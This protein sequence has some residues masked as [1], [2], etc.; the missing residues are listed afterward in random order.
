M[1]YYPCSWT[2]C[3][4]QNS[5]QNSQ[6]NNGWLEGISKL[7]ENL[8]NFN[9]IN[10]WSSL[11]FLIVAKGTSKAILRAV[12]I[13]RSYS[14]LR[15]ERNHREWPFASWSSR[16]TAPWTNKS[17]FVLVKPVWKQVKALAHAYNCCVNASLLLICPL[18]P[19]TFTYVGEPI[20]GVEF[21]GII[22]KLR[23]RNFVACLHSL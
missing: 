12:V 9:N 16:S 22:S 20:T 13:L 10:L 1:Y 23:K 11:G 7:L 6:N 19:L 18:Y 14:T 4:V 17:I 15:R 5:E 3:F 8:R 2:A 21:L